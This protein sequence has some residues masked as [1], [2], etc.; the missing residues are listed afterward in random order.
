MATLILADACTIRRHNVLLESRP[1]FVVVEAVA[2]A[3]DAR[4][5]ILAHRPDV[6][7]I[8]G[9][10]I[11]SDMCAAVAQVAAT[12]VDTRVSECRQTT[13]NRCARAKPLFARDCRRRPT[14]SKT[15]NAARLATP[16]AFA[17]RRF[18]AVN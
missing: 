3:E 15:D 4:A 5:R 17:S 9:S 7:V 8:A 16:P 6:I 14:C 10:T 18:A 11:H 12:E 2:N 1:G 13:R